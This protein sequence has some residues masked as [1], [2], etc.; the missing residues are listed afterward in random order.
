MDQFKL[1][2]ILNDKYE[3]FGLRAGG[4]G[5]VVFCHNVKG[6]PD[7]ALKSYLD[8]EESPEV[9]KRFIREAEAWIR[10]GQ[11]PFLMPLQGIVRVH[12]RPHILMPFCKNG[13]LRDRLHAA[14]ALQVEEVVLIATQIAIGLFHLHDLCKM[15]HR[16]LKPENILVDDGGSM[17][18]TDLGLVKGRGETEKS[19]PQKARPETQLTSYGSFIGTLSYASPEQLI[20]TASADFRTDVWAFGVIVF[21]LLMGRRAFEGPNSSEIVKSII[22]ASPAGWREF[23]TAAGSGLAKIVKKC[24]EKKPDH[25]FKTATELCKAM[26]QLICPGEMSG[27]LSWW[28]RD[29]RVRIR[30]K[31]IEAAWRTFFP[32]RSKGVESTTD[33]GEV[34]SSSR[35]FQFRKIGRYAEALIECDK[36]LGRID[37]PSS[38]IC[39]LLNGEQNG[40]AFLETGELRYKVKAPSSVVA[41]ILE[42]KMVIY[43]DLI[44]SGD[45]AD[46]HIAE[47]VDWAEI[48]QSRDPINCEIEIMCAQAFLKAPQYDRTIAIAKRLLQD[49]SKNA[50]IWWAYLVALNQSGDRNER[51]IVIL[52]HLLPALSEELNNHAQRVCG[53]ACMMLQEWPHAA[54]FFIEA[55]TLETNDLESL[56][57]ACACALNGRDS[58]LANKLYFQLVSVAPKSTFAQKL[59]KHFVN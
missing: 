7:V 53:K 6:G 16:D 21:E 3:V 12:G 49:H 11:R 19:V 17:A 40:V 15:I 52:E 9:E 10:V 14:G 27:K 8:S 25:R 50:R 18:I 57:D 48:I 43:I 20:D 38:N 13:S 58:E 2:T 46:D 32:E 39:K 1:G 55:Y 29:H 33:F 56:H 47:M 24:L 31:T 5:Y 34:A 36:V 42:L 26:D 23:E 4:M 59:A 28:Q 22:T 54:Q 41:E 37:D 45:P 44:E 51:N 30:N 35:A